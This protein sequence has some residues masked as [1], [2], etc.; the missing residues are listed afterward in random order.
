MICDKCGSNEDQF[1]VYSNKTHV[2]TSCHACGGMNTRRRQL[3][4]RGCV[5][6]Q[7][8]A[9]GLRLNEVSGEFTARVVINAT[10][11]PEGEKRFRAKVEAIKARRA[12]KHLSHKPIGHCFKC[13]GA[14]CQEFG[15]TPLGPETI[16]LCCD[17]IMSL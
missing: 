17:C 4:M 14:A 5:R 1:E 11:S 3:E 13:A 8:S 12:L 10:M 16:K 2:W 15:Y 7:A 9:T 6:A